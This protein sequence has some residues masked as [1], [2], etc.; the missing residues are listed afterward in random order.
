MNTATT[1]LKT[2]VSQAEHQKEI[3]N[4]KNISERLIEAA[5]LHLAASAYLEVNKPEAAFALVVKAFGHLS[6]I[7]EEQ[8]KSLDI[9]L[10]SLTQQIY[11]V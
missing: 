1:A 11:N 2:D 9:M 5:E 3:E 4:N 6:I 7:R 8:Q 10:N